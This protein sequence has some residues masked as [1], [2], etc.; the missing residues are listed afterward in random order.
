MEDGAVNLNTI[1]HPTDVYPAEEADCS[2]SWGEL[3]CNPPLVSQET[4]ES[5]VLDTI[6]INNKSS[7][8]SPHSQSTLLI[9]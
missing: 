4:T 2:S 5:Q 6:E 8:H 7:I 9:D 3:A 1:E